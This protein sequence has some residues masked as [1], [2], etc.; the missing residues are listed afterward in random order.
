MHNA[1]KRGIF[2]RAKE[3]NDV[4]P[5][6]AY[7][8][9]GATIAAALLTLSKNMFASYRCSVTGRACAGSHLY[10]LLLDNRMFHY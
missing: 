4:W 2:D 6:I 7:S 9:S 3:C 1:N 8:I 10:K 5:D